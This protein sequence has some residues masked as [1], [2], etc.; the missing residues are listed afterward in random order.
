MSHIRKLVIYTSNEEL[1]AHAANYPCLVNYN[2]FTKKGEIDDGVGHSAYVEFAAVDLSKEAPDYP[3]GEFDNIV[4]VGF[5]VPD[6][7]TRKKEK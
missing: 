7:L 6:T 2:P 1:A 3:T 4:L 5:E